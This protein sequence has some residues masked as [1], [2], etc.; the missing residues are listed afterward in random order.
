MASQ[1]G[2][3]KSALSKKP[4]SISQE[5]A[6]FVDRLSQPKHRHAYHAEGKTDEQKLSAKST[7]GLEMDFPGSS[8]Q[9]T[10][11]S[12]T[13]SLHRS[14]VSRS[15]VELRSKRSGTNANQL[16]V[17][18]VQRKL[19][20]SSL[21][22]SLSHELT[23]SVE[24]LAQPKSKK[25]AMHKNRLSLNLD[26]QWKALEEAYQ[27]NLQQALS[28][29]EHATSNLSSS[30]DS[31]CS[32]STNASFGSRSSLMGSHS[33]YQDGRFSGVDQTGK[34]K[35][36]SRERETSLGRRKAKSERLLASMDSLSF[37]INEKGIIG[38]KFSSVSGPSNASV[39]K[40]HTLSVERLSS[41]GSRLMSP[42]VSSSMKNKV[43]SETKINRASSST[44]LS[45]KGL[46]EGN[47]YPRSFSHR[48][49]LKRRNDIDVIGPKIKSLAGECLKIFNDFISWTMLS[50][51][52]N[53]ILLR[54]I[55]IYQVNFYFLEL[56]K[57]TQKRVFS[58]WMNAY[59]EQVR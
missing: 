49:N 1:E 22:G 24:R 20:P 10:P 32:I 50:S 44:S 55:M 17:P 21:K 25:T 6:A 52:L 23:A 27:P 18:S 59:L 58:K 34:S 45:T 39:P 56:Q 12:S 15:H 9:L 47:R 30:R 33:F 36:R 7:E 37:S 38:S 29:T 19:S 28:P 42:T 48:M 5:M 16:D 46:K 31:I 43:S 40:R 35:G 3:I 2:K 41:V 54:S 4:S 53:M 13:E 26:E 57:K 8:V 14:K 51:V 11:K